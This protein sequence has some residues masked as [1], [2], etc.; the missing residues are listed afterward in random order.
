MT[1]CIISHVLHT[2]KN[3]SFFAYSPYVNEMNIWLQYADKLIIVAPLEHYKLNAIHASYK[4]HNIEFCEAKKFNTL[5]L[6]AIFHSLIALPSNSWKIYKAM[7]ASDHIHLRCPGNMGLLG[8][9][10]QILFPKKK[11]SAKYAGNWDPKAK[12]PLS[13]RF[14]K[15]ILS[16]TFLTKNMRVLV[17]GHWKNQSKNILPFFTATYNEKEKIDVVPRVLQNTLQFIFVGS[18][19]KGK[20][21]LYAVQLIQKLKEDGHKVKLSLFGQGKER[22]ALRKSICANRL[23][24]TISLEENLDR[25]ALKAKYQTS[26]FLILPSKSEGWPKVVAEAMFWGCVP[27][28]TKVSCIPTMLDFGNRG[29]LLSEDINQDATQL[30]A[31]CSNQTDYNAKAK[32]AIDWSRNYTLDRFES[33]IKKIIQ[34]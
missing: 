21:P 20:Q 14:Q 6:K 32:A 28:A 16:N 4:H 11:K 25:E 24:A 19:T 13:Y 26:H 27:I 17:Y 18:L 5:S 7:K 33:E 3:H 15:W 8:C 30:A 29:L 34:S 23:E 22:E 2:E 10:V 1:F 12:Q 31:L 9:M